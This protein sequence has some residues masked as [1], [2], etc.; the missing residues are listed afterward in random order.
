MLAAMLPLLLTMTNEW[1]DMQTQIEQ[2]MARLRELIAEGH[3]ANERLQIQR[4]QRPMLREEMW[5]AID[6]RLCEPAITLKASNTHR[7]PAQIGEG[8]VP[9]KLA[10]MVVDVEVWPSCYGMVLARNE[11]N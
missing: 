11:K 10:R 1:A 9:P 3:I 2:S 5:R 8:Q 6:V 7:M 4:A